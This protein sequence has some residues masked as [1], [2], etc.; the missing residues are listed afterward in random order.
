MQEVRSKIEEAAAKGRFWIEN[1]FSDV[2]NDL[3][4][5]ACAIASTYVLTRLLEAEVEAYVAVAQLRKNQGQHAFVVTKDFIIDVTA[6]QFQNRVQKYLPPIIVVEREKAKE[7]FW[8]NVI[9]RLHSPQ[10]VIDFVSEP[11]W[12]EEQVPNLEHIKETY[13]DF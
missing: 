13:E 9:A 8:N 4:E 1:H 10:A 7:F 6:T 3:Y 12:P 11:A 5:G 2:F